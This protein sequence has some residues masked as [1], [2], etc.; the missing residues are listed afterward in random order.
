MAQLAKEQQQ[1][2]WLISLD[3]PS[4]FAIITYA[5]NRDLRQKI[6]TAY[7][8]R[9]SELGPNAGKWDN[10]DIMVSIL[11]L[12]QEEAKLLGY[13]N[14]A[15]LSLVPK[16]AKNTAQVNEFLSELA[17]RS[18]PFAREEWQELVQ[19]TQ[20]QH[21][22]ELLQ[23]WDIAYYSEKLRQQKFQLSQEEL[24]PYFPLPHV[25]QGL[26]TVVNKLY[27]IVIKERKD[28][29]EKWHAG[30]QFF[31]LY[32]ADNNLIGGFYIDLFARAQK[33]GGAWMDSCKTR[34]RDS[35]GKLQL[36]IAMLNCNF[37]APTDSSP[38]LLTHEEVLTLFHEFGHGLHHLLTQMEYFSISGINGVA[39]DAIELPSQL[40]ENWCWQTEGLD[41]LACHYQTH[42]KLPAA[43]LEKLQ[44]AKNFQAG[45]QMARQ[46]E[47]SLFDFHLHEATDINTPQQ[48]QNLLDQI[49][50][51]NAVVP[52]AVFNRFQHGFAHI[53]GGGYAAGYYSYKWAEVLSCDVFTQFKDHGIFDAKTARGFLEE[54]LSKGGSDDAMQLFVAFMGREP[55][56]DALLQDNGIE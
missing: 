47:F 24:R 17:E 19:F 12:R 10:S 3:F 8:T 49:R 7:V 41:L 26:F 21:N 31:D 16:M 42:A 28:G 11:Q 25:L 23:P 53:F 35:S 37:T 15:E 51:K 38:A 30:V 18:L 54:F 29:F 1:Q 9:A 6:Y 20:A 4:Y 55:K 50:Q 44:A 5:D 33:R 32:D 27:G 39:W 52:V 43:M 36:P 56:I 22:M 14:Y 45:M 40:M 34:N 48:I 13:H 46:L 2:G